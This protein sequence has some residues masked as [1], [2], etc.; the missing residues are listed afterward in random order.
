[1][2]DVP[3]SAFILPPLSFHPFIN[4]AHNLARLSRI[5]YISVY[6]SQGSQSLPR[7]VEPSQ[8]Q[9]V[10]SEKNSYPTRSLTNSCQSGDPDLHRCA[11]AAPNILRNFLR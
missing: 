2:K 1:M 6:V 8:K 10:F 5:R 9:E 4:A 11:T 3:A 7:R